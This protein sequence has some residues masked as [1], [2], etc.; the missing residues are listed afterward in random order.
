MRVVRLNSILVHVVT[1][2]LLTLDNA[3]QV[4]HH[5]QVMFLP[6]HSNLLKFHFEVLD[7]V[8]IHPVLGG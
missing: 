8:F 7:L 1:K 2:L 5:D 4:P 3:G 6:L